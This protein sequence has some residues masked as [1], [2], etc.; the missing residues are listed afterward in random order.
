MYDSD[1]YGLSDDYE[2]HEFC[3]DSMDSTREWNGSYTNL[4]WPLITLGKEL[5]NVV[6][7]KVLQVIIPK[8]YYNV[9]APNNVIQYQRGYDINTPDWMSNTASQNVITIPPGLYTTRLSLIQP[10]L[11]GM[12]AHGALVP[13]D[14]INWLAS[15]GSVQSQM[16]YAF[17]GGSTAA[18]KTYLLAP[19]TT[20]DRTGSEVTGSARTNMRRVFGMYGGAGPETVPLVAITNTTPTGPLGMTLPVYRGPQI[21]GGLGI[22]KRMDTAFVDEL[23]VP[24]IYLN[25]TTLGPSVNLFLNGCGIM[26]PPNSGAT[27]PQLCSIR[28]PQQTN[29]GEN[30]IY[31]DPDPQKYFKFGGNQKFPSSFDF[32]LSR[33]TDNDQVPL[34][35][36]G[37][38]F[39]V[40]LG[41]L[42]RKSNIERSF[43]SSTG[44]YSRV[45]KLVLAK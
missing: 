19:G 36:N 43:P 21:W 31:T 13:I 2:Y 9:T 39:V 7:L 14:T 30:I 4:N 10:L 5:E 34:D 23:E 41:V 26:I 16:K 24:T 27:G 45:T 33:G 25:S 8:T 44:G 20:L 3:I 28:V 37:G 17:I 22:S 12:N 42:T 15:S 32:Y 40:K 18:D 6:A 11:V 29:A 35:L 1:N 38:S